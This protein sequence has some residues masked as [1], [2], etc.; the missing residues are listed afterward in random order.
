MHGKVLLLAKQLLGT[1]LDIEVDHSVASSTSHMVGQGLSS[2]EIS[3]IACCGLAG[4]DLVFVIV[5]GKI[6]SVNVRLRF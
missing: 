1:V 3:D 4:W 2:A 5:S 6:D